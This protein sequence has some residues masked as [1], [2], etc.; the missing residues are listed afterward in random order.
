MCYMIYIA[1]IWPCGATPSLPVERRTVPAFDGCSCC[2]HELAAP[3]RTLI[4]SISTGVR[5]LADLNLERSAF[6]G[7][8]IFRAMHNSA[9]FVL[10]CDEVTCPQ[11][12]TEA[13]FKIPRTSLWKVI[14][15]NGTSISWLHGIPAPFGQAHVVSRSVKL[16]PHRFPLLAS[17]SKSIYVDGN[18]LIKRPL[19]LLLS[20]VRRADV[21]AF[22]FRRTPKEERRYLEH[23]LYRMNVPLKL[24][25]LYDKQLREYSRTFPLE[26]FSHIVYG[27]FVIRQHNPRTSAFNE[28]WLREFLAG[29][30]R[31]QVAFL[32]CLLI[33]AREHSLRFNFLNAPT[34]RPFLHP[35]F[36]KWLVHLSA[37]PIRRRHAGNETPS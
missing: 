21:S 1:Q 12:C 24:L 35:A 36:R 19:H 31:D 11:L 6:S 20:K 28:C 17:F 15:I 3:R 4:Y 2:A 32:Y 9:T 37:Q 33:A 10:F 30:P 34:N 8:G 18:I 27:K 23:R 29:I 7:E 26:D 13:P 16:A 14:Y 22:V 5:G 25:S